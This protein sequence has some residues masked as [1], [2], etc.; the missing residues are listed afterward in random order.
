MHLALIKEAIGP[1]LT[2][3]T[4]YM[5][6]G[7]LVKRLH[8]STLS[9]SFSGLLMPSWVHC[10][11]PGHPVCG[12]QYSNC[13]VS[14][15]TSF[16][17]LQLSSLS[18][19]GANWV[20]AAFMGISL[21]LSSLQICLETVD[22]IFCCLP[23]DDRQY[24]INVIEF[25]NPYR[26]PRRVYISTFQTQIILLVDI[27]SWFFQLNREWQNISTYRSSQWHLEKV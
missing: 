7:C 8:T 15:R 26:G 25:H 27:A 16:T 6:F 4:L 17:A 3:E 23:P 18:C 12:S 2:H 1:G 24:K 10:L 21:L 19:T 14:A 11:L 13:Y 9:R 22:T 5:M 20:V